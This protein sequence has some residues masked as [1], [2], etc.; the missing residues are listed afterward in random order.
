VQTLISF[1]CI[2]HLDMH[3]TSKYYHTLRHS[4]HI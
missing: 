3:H 4:S 2:R 1:P